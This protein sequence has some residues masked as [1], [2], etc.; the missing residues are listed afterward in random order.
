[1]PYSVLCVAFSYIEG[2]QAFQQFARVNQ[3]QRLSFKRTNTKDKKEH[4]ICSSAKQKPISRKG[5][6]V[7]RY[8]V[9]II[10]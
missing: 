10:C 2:I 9:K 6:K 1:M 4:I 5:N 7:F 8:H 3:T